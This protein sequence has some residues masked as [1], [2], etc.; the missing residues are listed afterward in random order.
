M[1]IL[2]IRKL[3]PHFKRPGEK[4]SMQFRFLH[5]IFVHA[6]LAVI[7]HKEN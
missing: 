6:V 2:T 3:T 1:Q 4:L 5:A 7:L